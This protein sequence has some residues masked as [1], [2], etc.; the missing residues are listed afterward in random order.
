[1]FF[2]FLYGN[3]KSIG[4]KIPID[5]QQGL[6]L[7]TAAQYKADGRY[8]EIAVSTNGGVEIAR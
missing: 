4:H 7:N 3:Y 2:Y 5:Y 1:M 6:V 8:A